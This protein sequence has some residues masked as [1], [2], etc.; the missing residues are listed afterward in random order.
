M[1]I[2]PINI[3]TALVG[4]IAAFGAWITQ[5]SAAKSNRLNN[6]ENAE[7]EAY[8]RARSMDLKT[9]ERQDEE[10]KELAE[11]NAALRIRLNEKNRAYIEQEKKIEDQQII[12]RALR[13]N[14]GV[15]ELPEQ[16]SEENHE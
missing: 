15:P 16:R 10:I 13:R 3:G 12:I 11:A 7:I 4:V 1:V 5:R 9:I 8:N 14:M 2:D 6:K